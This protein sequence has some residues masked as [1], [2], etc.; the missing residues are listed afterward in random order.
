M[1]ACY[2]T[3]RVKFFIETFRALCVARGHSSYKLV[4]MAIKGFHR[5]PYKERLRQ[6]V[7]HSFNRC[8][9]C[10]DLIVVYNVLSGG[11]NLDLSLFSYSAGAARLGRSSVQ[12][13]V[14]C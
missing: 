14:V 1:K 12:S 6:L 3:G 4:T 2:S 7:L 13:S 8:R 9:L 10:G 5:L 11:L